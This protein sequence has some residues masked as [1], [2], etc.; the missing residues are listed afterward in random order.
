M[1]IPETPTAVRELDLMKRLKDYADP[2]GQATWQAE[3]PRHGPELQQACEVLHA[4]IV[5]LVDNV[6]TP[7]LSRI[8]MHEMSTFTM[9]DS[10]HSLKVAHTMWHI[11]SPARRMTLTPPEIGLL[12]LSSFLHD[13]GMA[14]SSDERQTLLAPTSD[15]WLD[16]EFDMSL[17]DNVERLRQAA[18]ST[19]LGSSAVHLAALRLHQAQEAILCR[20]CRGRHASKERYEELLSELHS[21]PAKVQTPLPD[22]EACLGFDSASFHDKLVEICVS[23]GKDA[24]FLVEGDEN[25]PSYPRFRRDYHFGR[26]SADLHMVA[27]ALRLADVLDFDRERTPATLYPYLLPTNLSPAGDKSVL[28]WSKNLAVAKCEIEQDAVVFKGEC[29]DHIVHHA[30]VQ[31]CREIT[32][33]LES[34]LRSLEMH[35]GGMFPFA[36]PTSVKADI[37]ASGYTY[38]PY[39]F[40]LDDRRIYELLMGSAIYENPLVAIRELVQSA[41]DACRLRDAMDQSCQPFIQFSNKGRIRIRFEE[42]TPD[43]PTS[44]LMVADTG[45][46]MDDWVVKEYFLKVGRSFYRSPQFNSIR[47]A[48]RKTNENLDFAPVSEF[49][50]GFLSCF[51]LADRILIET[52]LWSPLRGDTRKR[53]LT[54]DGPT[55]LI[56][57][58]EEK[59]EGIDRFR[60][61]TV[62][63][64]LSRGTSSPGAKSP[65]NWTEVEAY[66]DEVCVSLPYVLDL[67]HIAADGGVS[68]RLLE[69][70]PSQVLIPPDRESM[71]LRISVAD[72]TAGLKGEIVLIN[73]LLARA[74]DEEAARISPVVPDRGDLPGSRTP[75]LLRGGF[76]VGPV[77]GL[78]ESFTTSRVA[79]A[80]LHLDWRE[81]PGRSYAATNLAR[82]GPADVSNVALNVFRLWL[83]AL[84]ANADAVPDGMVYHLFPRHLASLVRQPWLEKYSALDLYRLAVKGWVPEFRK[85]LEDGQNRLRVWES[86]KGDSIW[87]GSFES[88]LHRQLLDLTMP[89]VSRLEMHGSGNWYIKPPDEGW[90]TKLQ[91]CHDFITHPVDWGLFV[92]Y[93]GHADNLLFYQ[94]PGVREFN[95]THRSRVQRSF[96]DEELVSLSSL[97][98]KLANNRSFGRASTL[99][100]AEVALLD[101]VVENLGDLAIGTVNK[102]WPIR[103]FAGGLTANSGDASGDS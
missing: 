80:R 6:I 47:T 78:P 61:T 83:D 90:I 91:E 49:G 30:I 58:T 11:L 9:H 27:A 84:L 55:R 51:L 48:L 45:T 22:V 81:R 88:E 29:R 57:M 36:L 63:L 66:L 76:S 70:Q 20:Y 17:K 16:P 71:S 60:G 73:P 62:T 1:Q 64:F 99:D 67:E 25:N 69:P 46:G 8:G 7:R 2:K 95:L 42:P 98:Y 68:T 24:G 59:N 19:T 39:Q 74:A 26:C 72:V 12:V 40:E 94:Y 41:V 21:L 87:L 14:L 43:C 53:T 93:C 33:E 89:R 13:L 85:S 79:Y 101:R 82:T 10:R 44:K 50:I 92:E 103:S 100:H 102:S 54:I 23:H 4:N 38:V 56:R 34:T 52:A 96:R 97:L 31:F 75:L 5:T 28:E 86:S 32:L 15:L 18:E 65:P 35:A 77:P 3:G 37:I